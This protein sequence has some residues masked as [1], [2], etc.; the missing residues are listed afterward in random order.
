VDSDLI[1]RVIANLLN[2]AIKYSPPSGNITIGVTWGTSAKWVTL[3]ISDE[4][5]GITKD[6]QE[7]IF[8][9]FMQLKAKSH[10]IPS[11]RTSRG[12]GLTFCKL[13][14]EAHGGRIWVESDVGRGSKF[15]FNLPFIY[16][17]DE[18]ETDSQSEENKT[19]L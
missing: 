3:Y 8:E 16:F 17:P 15:C 9:K 5:Q 7:R 12:L 10:S 2:N 14:V 1:H 19:T 6:Y 13:A 4:G 11:F 18:E